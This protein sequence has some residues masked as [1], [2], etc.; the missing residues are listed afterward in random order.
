M[1]KLIFHILAIFSIAGVFAQANLSASQVLEK[2]I[3]SIVSSKGVEANFK[4]FNSGYSGSGNVKTLGSKFKVT[5]PD[6]EV[7]Y[8]GKE[9]YTYN[10]RA[11]ETTLVNPTEEELAQ[12]NPLAYV[13]GAQKTYD[14][15][16]STVKKTGKY[17]LELTPKV[18]G[19]EVKRITLT[20]DKQN[21]SPEK[22]VVE[23]ASGDP[24]S[25]DISSFKRVEIISN[26]EFEYPKT[27]FPK[28][29]IIDLR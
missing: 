28:V 17:V 8:N 25:A 16:F 21:Y 1:R 14:V 10:K 7:W 2:A 19:N 20:L 15:K 26:S 29:E 13:T 23:P 5:L 12:S 27:K 24:I 11:G 6:A 4:V 22:I 18:K 3:S 9:M